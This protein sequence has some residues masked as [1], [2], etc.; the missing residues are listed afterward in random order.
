MVRLYDSSAAA[1]SQR[2]MGSRALWS[3]VQPARV[4]AEIARRRA[5]FP[6]LDWGRGCHRLTNRGAKAA[7][8][9]PNHSSQ[10]PPSDFSPLMAPVNPGTNHGSRP[11]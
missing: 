1:L 5:F 9:Q 11:K 2:G 10:N 4:A 6:G 8:K 7:N 3:D